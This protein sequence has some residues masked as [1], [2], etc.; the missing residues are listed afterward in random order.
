MLP[1]W[2]GLHYRQY[3]EDHN[4]AVSVLATTAKRLGPNPSNVLGDTRH[5]RGHFQM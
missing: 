4:Y 3:K 5:G 2:V 1:P